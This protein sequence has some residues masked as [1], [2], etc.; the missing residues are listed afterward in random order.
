MRPWKYSQCMRF[1]FFFSF[2]VNSFYFFFFPAMQFIYDCSFIWCKQMKKK[3]NLTFRFGRCFIVI[4]LVYIE[5]DT[6]HII[7]KGERNI[8]RNCMAKKKRSH[9]FFFYSSFI[10]TGRHLFIVLHRS[11][12]VW[13]TS[14]EGS[15]SRRRRRNLWN[16]I[17]SIVVKMQQQQAIVEEMTKDEDVHRNKNV[18]KQQWGWMKRKTLYIFFSFLYLFIPSSYCVSVCVCIPFSSI[19]C[20]PLSII[21]N[22]FWTIITI[23]K[24][25]QFSKFPSR[26]TVVEFMRLS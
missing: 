25:F 13:Y 1:L 11:N 19:H 9:I 6:T 10:R 23:V 24:C 22:I 26:R 20:S 14:S 21:F 7:F 15:P 17:L 5:N 12:V 3:K 16:I 8:F 2:L 18:Y 4:I